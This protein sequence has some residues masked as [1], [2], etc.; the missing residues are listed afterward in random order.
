M[1]GPN[2]SNVNSFLGQLVTNL[3]W[4]IIVLKFPI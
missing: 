1:K 2:L 4:F 3:G